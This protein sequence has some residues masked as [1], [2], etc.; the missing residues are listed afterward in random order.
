MNTVHMHT[1]N[2]SAPQKKPY[3]ITILD[4]YSCVYVNV[5]QVSAGAPGAGVTGDANYL[6]GILRPELGSSGRTSGHQHQIIKFN[7]NLSVLSREQ[8]MGS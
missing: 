2:N 5:C 1:V 8:P 3:P 6:T 4:F 7:K